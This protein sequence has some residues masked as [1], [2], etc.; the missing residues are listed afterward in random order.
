MRR[1]AVAR[2]GVWL[3]GDLMRQVAVVLRR[4]FGKL[5]C[6]EGGSSRRGIVGSPHNL[7]NGSDF[8]LY[9]TFRQLHDLIDASRKVSIC[10]QDLPFTISHS[11]HTHMLSNRSFPILYL[12]LPPNNIPPTILHPHLK[13]AI[14]KLGHRHQTRPP[15]LLR[16]HHKPRAQTLHLRLLIPRFSRIICRE[17]R[18]HAALDNHANRLV[19]VAVCVVAVYAPGVECDDEIRCFVERRCG[20]VVI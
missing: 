19:P 8:V 3:C 9:M 12:H 5:K 7:R 15:I 18:R 11:F 20:K 2:V 4:K 14:Q 16:L 10:S 17:Q 1:S 13:L 6:A